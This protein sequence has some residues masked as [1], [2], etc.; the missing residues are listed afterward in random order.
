MSECFRTPSPC[1]DSLFKRESVF[2]FFIP[3]LEEEVDS[4]AHQAVE[5]GGVLWSANVLCKHCTRCLGNSLPLRGLP[6]QEGE[7]YISIFQLFSFSIYYLNDTF[8][9]I[10]YIFI[11]EPDYSYSL[12]TQIICS[13]IISFAPS[14]GKMLRSIQFY[15]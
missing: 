5:D 10:P 7:C 15:P 3:P 13:C 1:G 8:K 6:L 14:G 4:T 2:F 9:R 12:F 11:F